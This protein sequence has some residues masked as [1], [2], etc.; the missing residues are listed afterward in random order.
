MR[1]AAARSLSDQYRKAVEGHSPWTR[2]SKDPQPISVSDVAGSDLDD[3]L[4]QTIL[5]AGIG[6]LAFVPIVAAGELIGKFMIYFDHP[7]VS[8][9]MR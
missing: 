9:R 6:A 8:A 3:A 2:A 5:R 4:R 7:P 1:S